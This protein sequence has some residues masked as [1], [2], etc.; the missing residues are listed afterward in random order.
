[1]S[2]ATGASTHLAITSEAI[3]SNIR[4]IYCEKPV[5]NTLKDA[6]EMIRL[7]HGSSVILQVNHQRRFDGFYNGLK[8]FLH[9]GALGDINHVRFDYTRG[10]ANTGSHMFDLLRFLLGDVTWVEADYSIYK[11][12]TADDPNID[13]T[14]GFSTG[15]TGSIQTGADQS[16][17]LFEIEIIGDAGSLAI[18]NNG[19]VI[20]YQT[21][22]GVKH[23]GVPFQ[24][25]VKHGSMV[26]AVEE[27][28][29]CLEKH[30]ESVS[31]GEEGRASLEIICAFH[32]SAESGGKRINLPLRNNSRVINSS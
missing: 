2:I 32:E 11:S 31:S 7:C 3:K 25:N 21:N 27:L 14:I 30:E 5:A 9:Q 10:I 20:D 24:W 19:S 1:L 13:G 26:T 6:D 23:D 8:Q 29:L 15:V 28:T 18:R 22:D 17:G 12:H 16:R 4:A